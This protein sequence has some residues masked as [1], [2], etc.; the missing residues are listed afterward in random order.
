MSYHL[1]NWACSNSAPK[2]TPIVFL[3]GFAG[4]G[5][6]FLFLHSAERLMQRCCIAI[7]ALGHGGTDVPK[8][9][10][11]YGIEQVILDLDALFTALQIPQIHLVGYSMGGRMALAYAL[12]FPQRIKKLVL[13]SASPGLKTAVERAQRKRQDEELA[14]RIVEKGIHAF[15]DNWET[16]PLFASQR[17]VSIE[18]LDHQRKMRLSQIPEGLS[19]SLLGVGTGVQ[20]SY[21]DKIENLST[22]A[23]LLSGEIDMKF[24]NIA[25]EMKERMQTAEHRVI[26][27]AGHNIHLENPD[28]YIKNISEFLLD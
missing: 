12:N 24:T 18:R 5:E 1:W 4:T 2:R 13:E 11:R 17:Q 20:P 21:W 23:L 26:A 7:D 6:D 14:K 16:N 10:R 25:R 9:P 27:N 28:G 22:S 8:D 3:H 15:V 19:R